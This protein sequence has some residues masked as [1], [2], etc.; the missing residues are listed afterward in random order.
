MTNEEKDRKEAV[1]QSTPLVLL[2]GLTAGYWLKLCD[3]ER[4][5]FFS[6]WNDDNDDHDAPDDN[7]G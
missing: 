6:H 2:K 3:V 1:N 7:N 4:C 5:N